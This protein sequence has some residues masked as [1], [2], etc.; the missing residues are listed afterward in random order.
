M[1]LPTSRR[2]QRHLAT[3]VASPPEVGGRWRD[4]GQ[5]FRRACPDRNYNFVSYKATSLE[6]N[7]C[8]KEYSSPAGLVPAEAT[9]HQENDPMAP[10]YTSENTKVAYQL[11]WRF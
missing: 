10:I 7:S 5:D 3:V 8:T 4:Y 2:R 6:S 9:S 1:A 11:D